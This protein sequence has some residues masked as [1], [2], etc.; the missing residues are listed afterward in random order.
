M[1]CPFRIYAAPVARFDREGVSSHRGGL[2]S[3]E[4]APIE[5]ERL[6]HRVLLRFQRRRIFDDFVQWARSLVGS[7]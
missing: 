3:V 2:Q 7:L 4:V 1:A 5:G 6:R